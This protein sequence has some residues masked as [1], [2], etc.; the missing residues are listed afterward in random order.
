MVVPF[1]LICLD[2]DGTLLNANGTI[3][4][5]TIRL[6][7]KIEENGVSIAIVTGRPVIDARYFAKRISN[8]T[9]FI[10]ANGSVVGQVG[11]KEYLAKVPM[12]NKTVSALVEFSLDLGVMPLVYTANELVMSR[13]DFL[14]RSIWQ[15]LKWHGKTLKNLRLLR[16][17]EKFISYIQSPDIEVI[18]VNFHLQSKEQA[19]KA[20]ILLDIVC[21]QFAI[22]PFSDFVFELTEIGMNKSRGIQVLSEL[23]KVGPQEIIAFGDNDNDREML[24]FAGHSVAMG[25]ANP[26]IKKIAK[27]ITEENTEQGVAKELAR[28]YGF[29]DVVFR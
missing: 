10:G 6:L 21:T 9:Y 23:L 28:V 14:K 3:D 25:N 26:S 2:L 12:K 15:F 18:K 19:K 8:N 17:Q 13:T 4:R 20:Y 29:V 1:K 22:E 7:R 24:L 11:R 5:E 27:V 16:S